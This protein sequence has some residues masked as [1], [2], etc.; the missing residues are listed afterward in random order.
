MSVY[1]DKSYTEILKEAKSSSPTPGGGNV[2]AM[3]G[4]LGNAMVQMVANLTSGKEKYAQYQSQVDALVAESDKLMVRLE[5]L[6]YADMQ[7][8][9]KFMS[10]IKMPKETD[11]D[12]AARSAAM[13]KA[14]ITA[15]DVPMEIAEVCVKVTEL[16][17]ELAA[18]GNKGAI[19]DVGVGAYIAEASMHGALLS[20]EINLGGIKDEAYVKAA[21]EKMA[22][23]IQAAADNRAKAVEVVKERM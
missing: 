21:R 13:E 1:F 16:A 15:T 18:Y 19:S 6:C 11:E 12:K 9:D 23:L 2:S 10:A 17:V 5:E 8:F 20:A 22:S 3:V 14:S 4:C 7:V